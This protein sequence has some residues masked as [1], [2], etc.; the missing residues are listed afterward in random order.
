[1]SR[2]YNNFVTRVSDFD[3]TV[4]TTEHEFLEEK[5]TEKYP[6]LTML[7]QNDHSF[8]MKVTSL[9]NK[10]LKLEKGADDNICDQ[11][12]E[13]HSKEKEAVI[14]KCKI[15]NFEIIN[16]DDKN[17]KVTYK[18]HCGHISNTFSRN[19]LKD[20]RQSH[21]IKCQNNKNRLKYDDV[22][23]L[24]EDN[25]CTLLSKIYTNRSELLDY[26]CSCG[27][28]SKISY[29]CFDDGERCEAC[30]Q[31]RYKQTCLDR[32]HVDNVSKSEE[33]KK[34]ARETCNEN[35]GV[36]YCMQN[37][38]IKQRAEQTCL[39]KYSVKWAFTLPEVYEKIRATHKL[40]HGFEYPLQSVKIFKKAMK[41]AFS[42]K[43]YVSDDGK[44]WFVLGYENVCLDTLIKDENISCDDIKAGEDSE[45]PICK[46]ILKSDGKTHIWYPDV[47]VEGDNRLIEVKSFW[48]YNIDPCKM[49]D[50]MDC[51]E[52]NCELWV[53]DNN[54]NIY[55][56][57]FKDKDGY[58]YLNGN[59]MEI[60]LP[61][62]V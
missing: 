58:K 4:T 15:L 54:K 55:E 50:K 18:C 26:K 36:D 52:Y 53:Y 38:D 56:I 25:G 9:N 32:Y 41:T 40:N 31:D 7:C 60:G 10:L 23:K 35:H 45:I 59:K 46:Y 12:I 27:N 34:K 22:K 29:A 28:I 2:Q 33:F 62:I 61:I 44:T 1:M 42:R 16:Y 30:R 21:C 43:E 47:W 51:C 6:S 17:R 24:F 5:K 8:T 37:K 39:E 19:I 14:E 57:V 49:K 13:K 20:E 11:C 3:V 48:T